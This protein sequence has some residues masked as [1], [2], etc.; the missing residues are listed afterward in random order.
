[1]PSTVRQPSD[2]KSQAGGPPAG[3]GPPGARPRRLD[4]RARERQIIEGAIAFFA[5]VGLDGHTRELAR[6]LGITQ[7]LLYR[8][9]PSKQDL[10]ERI[11]EELYLR[12]WKPEWEAVVA[13]AS[14]PTGER[15]RRFETDY[16]R[17]IHDYAWLRI[18]VSAGIKGYDLPRR[19]LGMVRARIFAPLLAA[20][21]GEHGLPGPDDHPLGEDEFELLFGIHGALVYVGLR[22]LVYG[23]AVPPDADGLR[24]SLL[25]AALPGLRETHCALVRRDMARGTPPARLAGPSRAATEGS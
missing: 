20:M 12:R 15:F 8:Y 6:R 1:M 5:E 23:V 11:Y 13:D 19:Y 3:A 22:G 18:F 17:T 2:R 10:I 9:F 14:L 25:D 16:Q 7:P 4:A 24:A 21:R